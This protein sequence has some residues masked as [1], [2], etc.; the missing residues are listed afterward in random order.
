[1]S[2]NACVYIHL[3]SNP[4]FTKQT[5]NAFP[6]VAVRS[7]YRR[8]PCLD[9][10]IA[11]WSRR[12]LHHILDRHSAALARQS[13]GWPCLLAA[14]HEHVHTLHLFTSVPSLAMQLQTDE[15]KGNGNW[16]GVLVGMLERP[17]VHDVLVNKRRIA[18]GDRIR[19]KFVVGSLFI[20]LKCP[21][22]CREYVA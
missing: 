3:L 2:A 1:M 7:P 16:L 10:L 6:A 15:C 13:K 8:A 11:R 18:M 22:I 14:C 17:G 12:V 4:M 21:A 5:S 19:L 20:H 9:C